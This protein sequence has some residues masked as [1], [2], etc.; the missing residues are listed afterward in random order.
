MSVIETTG[1]LSPPPGAITSRIADY[2]AGLRVGELSPQLRRFARHMLLD[3]LGCMVSGAQTP[4]GRAALAFARNTPLAQ[5][6]LIGGGDRVSV[7]RAAFANTVCCNALDFEPVGPEGHVGAVAIP[8]A[9]ALADWLDVSGK[10]LLAAVVAGLEVGGRIGA[11]WRRPSS[12]AANGTPL[13]RGTPHAVFSA[14]A[15]AALLLGLDRETTRHAIG[16]AG[17]SAHVPTLRKA[18]S[19]R[20]P[21]MTKYDHLGGMAQGGI[22][23]VRLAQ[24][25]FTGDLELFEGDLGM[26]RFAGA[27]GCDWSLLEEFGGDFMIAPTFFKAFPCILYENPVLRALRKIVEERGVQPEEIE[28]IVIRPSRAGAAQHGDGRGGPMAQWMS[29]RL[30]AAHAICNTRPYHAWHDGKPLPA[31]IARLVDVTTIEPYVA[32]PGEQKGLYWEGYSP[33]H[34]TV[35]TKD[36]AYEERVVHLER[37]TEEALVT[38]FLDNVAPIIGAVRAEELAEMILAVEELPRARML[39]DRLWE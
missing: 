20:E 4:S 24:Q 30:N 3:C 37:M 2:I 19:L 6:R 36:A 22:D 25:G 18:M 39:L 16:I 8:T 35:V 5:A 21:P 14:A 29:L 12:I 38:K 9:L 13:V 1:E 28:R 27:L 34:V 17:Y 11:A 33:A 15:P 26:W 10:A 31:R 7:E 23:A 32:A